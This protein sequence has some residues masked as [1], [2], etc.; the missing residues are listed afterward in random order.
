MWKP[1]CLPSSLFE[2]SPP[3][4]SV[5]NQFCAYLKPRVTASTPSSDALAQGVPLTRGCSFT[6]P[7]DFDRELAGWLPEANARTVRRLGGNHRRVDDVF[8]TV[9]AI[10]T[11]AP[12]VWELMG[13]RSGALN[14][15]SCAVIQSGR[16]HKTPEASNGKE[17]YANYC[18]DQRSSFDQ[19][20]GTP[21]DTAVR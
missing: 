10:N 18:E 14:R 9:M 2:S 3:G 16:C 21:I 7:D 6:G 8:S 19:P 12:V 5:H 4:C 17:A 11:S 15:V 1:A 20:G 13:A